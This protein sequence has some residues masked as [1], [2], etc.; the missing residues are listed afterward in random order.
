MLREQ[1]E[2]LENINTRSFWRFGCYHMFQDG[3]AGIVILYVYGTVVVCMSEE[4]VLWRKG[5]L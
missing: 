2:T 4:V 3:G 5:C 1:S